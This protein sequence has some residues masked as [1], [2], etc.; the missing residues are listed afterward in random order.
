MSCARSAAFG[1]SVT[2]SS[3]IGGS[4]R[5]SVAKG[6]VAM[7]GMGRSDVQ[8]ANAINE[9]AHLPSPVP[10]VA[11]VITAEG[12]D[13]DGSKADQPDFSACRDADA[14]SKGIGDGW[15]FRVAYRVTAQAR[16][17]AKYGRPNGSATSADVLV[18]STATTD[19]ATCTQ[20]PGYKA[21]MH[22]TRDPIYDP[23]DSSTL[24]GV[25][26]TICGRGGDRR[27]VVVVY[28]ARAVDMAEFVLDLDAS[29]AANTCDPDR[30]TILEQSDGSRLR[31]EESVDPA[32]GREIERLKALHSDS[33]QKGKV[34]LIQT[35][36]GDPAASPITES[37]DYEAFR[38]VFT[39]DTQ[40]AVGHL[41]DGWAINAHDALTTVV[42]AIAAIPLKDPVRAASVH[43]S[44]ANTFQNGAVPGAIHAGLMFDDAGNIVGEPQ[45]VRL[46]PL[47]DDSSTAPR[48]VA[49]T[50]AEGGPDTA[51]P[52]GCN[53]KV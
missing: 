44:I 32:D 18:K 22:P 35:A 23:S 38:A 14:Y 51:N 33:F 24:K 53:V 15:F 39:G 10:M 4:G 41:D 37:K 6:V 50:P 20:V 28:T 21:L 3:P 36:F 45:V 17:L 16:Q 5:R 1:N 42:G 40:F 13:T 52:G 34:R 46:C 48:T 9:V 47:P 31:S 8:S 30:V 43:T 26:N 19:P 29:Y 7:V 11:D 49:V 12:F 27:G 2:S 25:V